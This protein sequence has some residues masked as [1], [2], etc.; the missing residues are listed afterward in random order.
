MKLKSLTHKGMPQVPQ[1][2]TNKTHLSLTYYPTTSDI[3]CS[4]SW[5]DQCI[6]TFPHSKTCR[7]VISAKSMNNISE[8]F[9]ES[10]LGLLGEK[11]ER[12]LCAMPPPTFFSA[13]IFSND[14]IEAFGQSTFNGGSFAN[15]T[16]GFGG[17]WSRS[18]SW[19]MT[20]KKFR[21]S[22]KR[23]WSNFGALT[24]DRTLLSLLALF[25]S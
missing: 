2:K 21:K 11:R 10:N 14:N 24:F 19:I 3:F 8:K 25:Y 17:C 13:E 7:Q 16:G 22:Q 1:D 20:K 23:R 18:R 5:F 15:L 12:Y 4:T 6:Q 9:W